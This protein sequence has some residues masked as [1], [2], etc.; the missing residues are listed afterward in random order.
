MFDKC[1]GEFGTNWW[2]RFGE[3]TP[4]LT[5]F[6]I[7][8][9]SLTCSTSGCERNLSTFKSIH[10]KKGNRLKHKR[11]HALVYVK[12]NSLL[13]ERNIRRRV[14]KFDPI[15][16]EAID[17]DDEWISEVEDPIFPDDLSWLEEYEPTIDDVPLLDDDMRF[18][19]PSY[20]P[21]SK[22]KNVKSSSKEI[23]KS[24][25]KMKILDALLRNEDEIEDLTLHPHIDTL[26][27]D[28]CND[29]HVDVSGYDDED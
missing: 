18:D 27:I 6:A 2:E 8:V 23:S 28:D 25:N 11:L 21:S 3:E 7:C 13:R 19:E 14:K 5:K 1:L 4:E 9:L 26:N 22:K 15:L 10:T 24:K 16:V 12:Y 29:I 17:S 20:A